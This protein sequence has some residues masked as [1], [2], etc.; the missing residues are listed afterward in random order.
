MKAVVSCISYGLGN[1]LLQFAAGYGLAH[2][3]GRPLDLDVSWFDKDPGTTEPRSLLLTEILPRETY[4]RKLH[5]TRL[6]H[7]K[8][9]TVRAL[10]L[11]L[12]RPYRYGAPLWNPARDTVESFESIQ[13][14]VTITGVPS[15]LH[16]LYYERNQILS[17]ITKGLSEKS[18]SLQNSEY[19]FVHVRLGDF[20]ARPHVRAKM[21]QLS[22]EYYGAAMR[23]YE[24]ERGE[25]QWILLSDEPDKALDRMPQGFSIS[26]HEG[27][28]EI[29]DLNIM[30]RSQGGVIANST[31][32]LWGGILADHNGGT[33]VAPSVWR[34]DGRPAPKLP[35]TWLRI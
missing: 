8:D 15:Y 34:R 9:F 7:L 28:S 32:S 16:A 20:V 5:Y 27:G 24:Q 30:A 6:Q 35:D 4:R 12:K 14:P 23:R 31:F 1:Q 3:L 18:R 21:E 29:E 26:A 33:V 25:T 13:R 22:Q 10:T 19:A 17:M 11:S 2:H